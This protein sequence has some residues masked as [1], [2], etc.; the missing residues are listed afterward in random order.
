MASSHTT[1]A[2]GTEVQPLIKTAT[3]STTTKVK[4]MLER[5]ATGIL[6]SGKVVNRKGGREEGVVE[7]CRWQL[8][9]WNVGKADDVDSKRSGWKWKKPSLMSV[10]WPLRWTG[11]GYL[12]N[13]GGRRFK[14][15][16]RWFCIEFI[17]VTLVNKMVQASAV[18]FCSKLSA[19]CIMHSASKGKS[20]STT[21][22]PTLPS[23][24][25]PP[26][27]FPLAITTLSSVCVCVCF[28]K[29]CVDLERRTSR[30]SCII[31]CETHEGRDHIIFAFPPLLSRN[32]SEA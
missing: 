10:F 14:A 12:Y 8:G 24:T 32:M 2:A 7:N 1:S 26:A 16:S 31:S 23:F 29:L 20:L 17:G 21:I 11:K 4:V 5:S 13:E 25:L 6:K 15:C 28:K 30:L 19:H 22:P 9:Q 3:T 18:Q 27:P